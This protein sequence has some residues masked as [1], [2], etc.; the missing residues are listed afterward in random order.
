LAFGALR[1]LHRKIDLIAF[2]I[3][4]NAIINKVTM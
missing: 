1:D 3:K 4:A 2:P